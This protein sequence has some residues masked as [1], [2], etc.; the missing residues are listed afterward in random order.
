MQLPSNMKRYYG[1]FF[2]YF[3]F[4]LNYGQVQNVITLDLSYQCPI[5][6][7]KQLSN[8]CWNCNILWKLQ[9]DIFVSIIIIIIIIFLQLYHDNFE[10]F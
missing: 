2:C 6:F 3:I 9:L 1:N 4:Q 5:I 8:N 10:S 7:S